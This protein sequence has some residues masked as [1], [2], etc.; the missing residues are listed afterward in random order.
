[1]WWDISSYFLSISLHC[2][3]NVFV[4]N[5]HHLL[6]SSN[7]NVQG[8]KNWYLFCHR[9]T[10]NQTIG[11]I[12]ICNRNYVIWLTHLPLVPHICVSELGHHKFRDCACR[13]FGTKP[14]PKPV[15]TYCQLDSWKRISVKFE[16]E[17][18]HFHSRKCIWKCHL[19]ERRPFCSGGDE[20]TT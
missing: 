7:S 3:R 17:F 5:L 15:L 1:M 6:N 8:M 10:A 13:L 18:Y 2:L 20:L 14:L 9:Q 12:N 4:E 16:S 11:K 19:P